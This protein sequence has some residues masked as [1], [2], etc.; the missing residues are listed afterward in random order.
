MPPR[1]IIGLAAA[2]LLMA[3]ATTTPAAET[4]SARA[5]QAPP[6][7]A[8]FMEEA[9]M[10]GMAEVELGKLAERR[11]ANPKV[12]QFGKRMVTDHSKVNAQLKQL[13]ARKGVTLP[14]DIGS[15]HEAL[16]TK[17]SGLSGAD[18]D[19]AYIDAMKEDH[20]K[21]IDAFKQAA[22]S[23]P[24]KDVRSF[25]KKT[26]PTLE[27]HQKQVDQIEPALSRT[28]EPRHASRGR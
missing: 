27:A 24:D 28:G 6:E 8:S 25:A 10:G 23:S 19:K 20:E 13:A 4:H 2:S 21:D 22:A 17:L 14:K 11:A 12:K 7:V 26:L 3:A 16:R 5:K 1:K 18:F 9:A 15:E